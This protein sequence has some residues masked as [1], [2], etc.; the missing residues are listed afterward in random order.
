MLFNSLEFVIFFPCVI[1]LYF[2]INERYK[3]IWLLLASYIFYMSWNP[4][5]ALL[6]AFATV[7]T[8]FLGLYLDKKKRSKI[9]MTV[10]LIIVFSALVYF[11]YSNFLISQ[12][13]HVINIFHFQLISHFDIVLPVGISFFTF[14]AA[15]YLIDIYKKE[16]KAERNF[17]KYA[18]FISFFPQLV[19]GPIE[20]SKDLLNQFDNTKNYRPNRV[21]HG[22]LI[23]LWGFFLKIVI[24][25]RCALIADYTFANYEHL[26]GIQLIAGATAFSFQIYCDFMG[27]STI[28]RGAAK[29]LGINLTENFRMPYFSSSIKEFWRRWHISLS[30]WLRDYL[31][32]PLGGSRKGKLITYRNILL[33]F[34]ISGLWHGAGWNYICWGGNTRF[35]YNNQ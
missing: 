32:I 3:K 33:T 5:F 7:I 30:Y 25:D 23:M 13:N 16:T 6:L 11:K 35:F 34:L 9:T 1:T 28:A 19:A 22:L 15:G 4:K 10:I 8:F 29:I 26:K 20:R 2:A 21:F 17:I 18:L 27:Y 12:I 14:Q 24:A 31:Y